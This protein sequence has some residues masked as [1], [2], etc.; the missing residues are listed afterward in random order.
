MAEQGPTQEELDDAKTYMTGSFPL[1]LSSTSNI[2]S[3]LVAMQ[4]EN[5]GMDYMDERKQ[6]IES[7]T[8]EQARRVAGDLL[9]PDRLA[10]VVVGRPEG[11]E[12]T[13]EAPEIGDG[14]S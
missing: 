12:P 1:R 4:Q 13:R 10:V 7:V 14:A 5:L 2:A 11:V 9:H 8:L 6:L 3:I